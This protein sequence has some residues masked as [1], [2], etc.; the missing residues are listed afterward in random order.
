M[1]PKFWTWMTNVKL[2]YAEAREGLGK[3]SDWGHAENEVCAA[4]P[5][6]FRN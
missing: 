5:A 1:I 2:G 6:S 4:Q 3:E